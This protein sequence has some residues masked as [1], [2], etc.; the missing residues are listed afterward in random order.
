MGSQATFD[1]SFGSEIPILHYENTSAVVLVTR[2]VVIEALQKTFGF[3]SQTSCEAVMNGNGTSMLM[4]SI[5]DRQ[6]KT[7]LVK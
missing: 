2:A 6:I 7:R 5:D 3:E 1:S 4:P